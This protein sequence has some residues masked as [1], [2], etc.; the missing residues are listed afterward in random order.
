MC[1][2]T[3]LSLVISVRVQNVK[4]AHHVTKI[5]ACM[6]PYINGFFLVTCMCRQYYITRDYTYA[7]SILLPSVM[8]MDPSMDLR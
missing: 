5:S 1:V 8:L 3:Y 2:F 4:V 7:H 6:A